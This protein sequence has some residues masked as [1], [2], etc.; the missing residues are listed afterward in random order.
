[1]TKKDL[2]VGMV[3]EVKDNITDECSL[4]MIL[5]SKYS[6]LCLSGSTVWFP[7]HDL[8]EDLVLDE[9]EITKVFDICS[10][11]STAHKLSTED[12]TLLWKRTKYYN[13]K[14][15]CVS[16]NGFNGGHYTVGKIYEFKDGHITSDCG[17]TIPSVT[18]IKSFKDWCNYTSAK[19]I[20][21]VE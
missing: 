4:C 17:E 20:E 9:Y 14:V 11:N 1:M 5:P 19:F 12:R 10:Y 13:G 2:K 15:V 21:V 3:V 6:D 16:L 7:L 18:P 8:D